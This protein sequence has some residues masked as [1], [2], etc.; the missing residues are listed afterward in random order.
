MNDLKI[1]KEKE[2]VLF[3]ITL[4]CYKKHK[5]SASLCENCN[6]LVSYAYERIEH[7]PFMKT[8]TFCSNCKTH[9]YNT[10]MREKIKEVM[11]FSGPRML[12]YHPLTALSHLIHSK[13]LR[14]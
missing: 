5:T 7:C 3:M 11:A 2:M 6:S 13:I 4:F 1:K 8:K 12:L 10:S 14:R 9:C